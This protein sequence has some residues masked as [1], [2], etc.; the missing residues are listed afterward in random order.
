MKQN[1][2]IIKQVLFNLRNKS[3]KLWAHLKSL[4]N[5]TVRNDIPINA[6]ILNNF[7]ANVF[8]QASQY[9]KNQA[10]TIPHS[11][12]VKCS[13][14]S[15]PVSDSEVCS[16]V[17]SLSNSQSL[18][19][20]G[21]LPDII[22]Y[23][24]HYKDHQLTYIFNLSFSQ[25]VFLNLLKNA[26]VVPIHNNHKRD[27]P[28]NYRP[29]SILTIFSKV[30]EKLFYSRFISFINRNNILHTN[31]FG[32]RSEKST[33]LALTQVISSLLTKCNFNKKVTLA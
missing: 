13:M 25:S 3:A 21:I 11:D 23:F 29:I 30:L 18:G 20:D 16:N 15:A 10:H 1:A 22:K 32:F 5:P 31:Q 7:F 27:D 9:H 14:F 26:I 33:L 28:H 8:K 17:L 6:N 4:I 19:S 12:F 24:I 2:I